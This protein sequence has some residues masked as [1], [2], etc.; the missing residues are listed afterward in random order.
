MSQ[1]IE[2]RIVEMQFDNKDFEKNAKQTLNTI[3]DLKKSLN[4]DAASKS[5]SNFGKSV[6]NLDISTI[7]TGVQK[8]A[9]RFSAAG[10]ASMRVIS[11][12]VD[13]AMKAGSKIASYLAKPMNTVVS[14]GWQRAMNIEDAK[15]QLEGLGVTWNSIKDDINYGVESTAYGL[16]AAA[17]A[18]SSLVASGVQVGDA[19]KGALR[20]ISGVAAMT[21]SSYEEISPIFTTVAG[22]GKVMTMQLRQLESRGLNVAASMA[23]VFNQINEGT[24]TV[25]ASVEESVKK[26]TKG[27]K[28][29]EAQVREF[30]TNGKIGFAEFSTAMDQAFG[31]HAKDANKTFYGALSNVNAALKKIGAEFATPLINSAVPVL[32]KVRLF[33][34]EI[35]AA[36]PGIF[37]FAKKIF[38]LGSNILSNTIGKAIDY[39]KND[40]TGVSNITRGFQNILQALVRVLASVKLAFMEVFPATGKVGD[41]INSA[42]EGFESLTKALIPNERAMAIIKNALVAVLT[43]TKNA[44]AL[45]KPVAK[46]LISVTVT[47]TKIATAIAFLTHAMMGQLVQ[48]VTHSKL[49]GEIQ[50]KGGLLAFVIDKVSSVFE[51]LR[52]ALA[53]NNS[54]F[55]NVAN[56]FIKIASIVGG[57][58]GGV[59]GKLVSEVMNIISTIKSG[60]SIFDYLKTKIM[61]VKDSIKNAIEYL[62]QF[63]IAA[64]AI[65]GLEKVFTIIALTIQKVKSSFSGFFDDLK[66][67]GSILDYVKQVVEKLKKT[68]S[69]LWNGIKNGSGPAFSKIK[70]FIDNLK[71]IPLVSS[72]VDNIKWIINGI[73]SGISNLIKLVKSLFTSAKDGASKTGSAVKPLMAD[74]TFMEKALNVLLTILKVLGAAIAGIIA[75]AVGIFNTAVSFIRSLELGKLFD[76]LKDLGGR[77]KDLH[78]IQTAIDAFKNSGGS[79]LAVIEALWDKMKSLFDIMGEAGNRV[80]NFFG[81]KIADVVKKIVGLF[82]G[83]S[84]GA[85]KMSGATSKVHKS[86]DGLKGK[87]GTVGNFVVDKLTYVRESGFLTKVLLVA[88]VGAI[89]KALIQIP[90]AISKF[91]KSITGK[92]GLIGSITGLVKNTSGFLSSMQQGLAGEK[93][94]FAS[95]T[96]A[97][98][99]WGKAQ[100]RSNLEAI[101]E[102]IRNIAI[103]VGILAV[104]LAALSFIPADKLKTAAITLG[105]FAGVLV[106]FSAALALISKNPM[107]DYIFKSFAA[108]M[109][110]VAISIAIIATA[111]AIMGLLLKNA[112]NLDGVVKALW[113]IGGILVAMAGVAILIAKLDKSKATL[114]GALYLIAFGTAIAIVAG[115]FKTISKAVQTFESADSIY[116][117]LWVVVAV[118]GAFAVAA[119]VASRIKLGSVLAIGVLALI[120][121]KVMTVMSQVLGSEVVQILA[122][123]LV[124]FKNA[125]VKIIITVTAIVAVMEVLITLISTFLVKT[126]ATAGKNLA[127]AGAAFLMFGGGLALVALAF[128]QF[129]KIKL[130]GTGMT[131]LFISLGALLVVFTLIFVIASKCND[132]TKGMVK[133]AGTVALL[134]V[135]LVACMAAA[136]LAEKVDPLSMLKAAAMLLTLVVAMFILTKA[137]QGTSALKFGTIM[138]MV[139]GMVLIV[140]MLMVLALMCDDETTFVNLWKAMGLI[141]AVM[142]SMAA[143]LAAAGQIRTGQSWKPIVSMIAMLGVIFAGLILLSQNIKSGEDIAGLIIISGIVVGII[144]ALMGMLRSFLNFAKQNNMGQSKAVTKAMMAFAI[145]VGALA[146]VSGVLVVLDKC[147]EL[148]GGLVG[149]VAIAMTMV[150][151]LAMLSVA[152]MKMSKGT[153]ADTGTLIKTGI[154]MGALIVAMLAVTGVLAVLDTL[155]VENGLIDKAH[156]LMLAMG[157]LAGLTLAFTKFGDA[158]AGTFKALGVLGA[159][160]ATFAVLSQVFKLLDALQLDG[161]LEKSQILM[162]T[163][164][165]LTVL[166]IVLGK[167]GSDSSGLMGIAGLALM[168]GVLA[169]LSLVFRLITALPLEGMLPKSQ[170]LMLVMAELSAILIVFGIFGSNM[171]QA[172]LGVAGLTVM[173]L[174]FGTLSVIAMLLTALPLEGMLPKTQ[175]IMLV[176]AEMTALLIIMGVLGSYMGMALIGVVALTLMTAIFT[177]LSLV[178]VMLSGIPLEGMLAKTQI[179]MLVLFELAAIMVVLGIPAVA[180]FALLGGLATI[181]LSLMVVVFGILALICRVIISDMKLDGLLPKV[182]IIVLVLFELAVIMVLLGI[183]IVCAF[184][185]LG[186]IATVALS[187]MVVVFGILAIICKLIVSEIPLNGLMEK[188]QILV[189]TLF[190]LVAIME[191]MGV[192]LPLAQAAL[193][194]LPTFLAIILA[195]VTITTAIMLLKDVQPEKMREVIDILVESIYK[196]IQVIKDF[197]QDGAGSLLLLA[198]GIGAIGAACILAAAGVNALAAAFMM[199]ASSL[200]MLSPQILL[201]FNSIAVGVTNACTAVVNAITLTGTTIVMTVTMVI[202]GVIAA[203]FGGITMILTAGKTLGSGLVDG[204]KTSVLD[205]TKV[206]PD[207]LQAIVSGVAGIAGGI[208]NAGKSMGSKL[209]EGFRNATGWH[210]PPEFLVKFFKDAG[211]TVNEK[212]EGVTDL[213]EGTG[214]DW[215]SALSKGL[216]NTDWKAL[217]L[218]MISN[219]T[220]GL[221]LG[222]G[223]FMAEISK[224]LN[225]SSLLGGADPRQAQID[226]LES[227]IKLRQGDIKKYTAGMDGQV[228]PSGVQNKISGINKEIGVYQTQLERVKREQ[229]A[230]SGSAKSLTDMLGGLGDAFGDTG[231]G[232][233]GAADQMEDFEKKLTD[234][235]EGQMDI[236]SK[237]EKKSA[238]SKTELLENMRSQ[239]QGMTEWAND[240]AILATKGID[241][242]LYEK[243]AMM[244]PQGAEYVGAFKEMTTEELAEANK[245]WGQSLVLP[246]TVAKGVTLSFNQLGQ[247]LMAGQAAGILAGTDETVTQMEISE[248]Q[249]KDKAYEV[250]DAN[251]PAKEFIKLGRYMMEGLAKGIAA[252]ARLPINEMVNVCSKIYTEAKANLSPSFFYT[253]GVGIVDGLTAGLQDEKALER[254]SAQL[255]ALAALIRASKPK[256]FEENSPSKITEDIG[257]GLVEGL[258]QGIG[259]KHELVTDAMGNLSDDAADAM[260]ATI[261]GIAQS[262]LDDDEFTPVI[263]PVLDLSNVQS[264]ARQLNNMFTTNQALSALS[265]FGD[266]QNEQLNGQN[267]TSRLG[268]TFIQNNYSP[269]ALNRI[270]IYRQTKNQFAQYKEAMQ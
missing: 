58:V 184:A 118:M 72:F 243:L 166:Q 71:Q 171:G 114:R 9:D 11:N 205:I 256:D 25:D 109:L 89:L 65:N 37:D 269:K 129:S 79:L 191:T 137:A 108:N 95:L 82:S 200:M 40:F 128:D 73:T 156:V 61:A 157:E 123:N 227:K 185:L 253:I 33:I 126:I 29:S 164:A 208:L 254:L 194:G 168:V 38:Y 144:A 188:T 145:M 24:L 155:S 46:I 59:I 5:L 177:V 18:A 148:S 212:A 262:L 223:D 32:N 52:T 245:L 140:G 92:D 209:V 125:L 88:Y 105:L 49:Y 56:W 41:T 244:G 186:G 22:Q 225:F 67:N 13:F 130:E 231:K 116:S 161:M 44:F 3:D 239:I 122:Q 270:E 224:L 237:F 132:V 133:I 131:S 27:A 217:G 229:D 178:C 149:K 236:F 68:F 50:K 81:G 34:N 120:F 143:V 15:F 86:L 248:N 97:I 215:G 154:V 106:V 195:L 138:G 14:G 98:K 17:K 235:L 252:N 60:G 94:L 158:D 36:M 193:V 203:I 162:L 117:A 246:S 104:S 258:A 197:G 119:L 241:Q 153:S 172:M 47:V 19:M 242:G 182:E 238:M 69:D 57:F 268:T 87:F 21:N 165:E 51:K 28:V 6:K 112:E 170:I 230:T 1:S 247:N 233:G 83:Y 264:G 257:I 176:M 136:K 226:A 192:M 99:N 220:G 150:G 159:L 207:I 181:A 110:S 173:V 10:I 179:V 35:K 189:L 228:L 266:L 74:M 152:I 30:V 53:E 124:F 100:K 198:L 70:E 16:D 265:A 111:V 146:V 214:E 45:L 169:L 218:G 64:K 204:F 8:I 66:F 84:A 121:S 180:M 23:K 211:V 151:A 216:K 141:G 240:M 4:F 96:D 251:S 2:N 187:L 90:T 48:L 175:I 250:V 39:M 76:S 12:V 259:E 107:D 101:P 183:P 163:L 234:T 91:S 199:F 20:G 219:L 167:L 190:E 255:E 115:A 85:D 160:V 31:E 196:I 78:L 267:G 249:V 102:I 147:V 222:E 139:L 42:A 93:G 206:I 213:F 43:I 7:Q 260:K 54:F 261:A 232:A 221:K 142:L 80:F 134:G 113:I 26:L 62:K 174:L 127:M 75:S 103:S 55:A 77:I 63:P 201:F 202:T 263:T 135:G 210:S